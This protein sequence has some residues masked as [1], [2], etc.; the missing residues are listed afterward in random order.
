MEHEKHK[1][2]SPEDRAAALA[3][4]AESDQSIVKVAAELGIDHK[5]LWRWVNKAKL[6]QI[7]PA[8]ELPVEARRRIRDLERQNA[9]LQRDLDFQKKAQAFF[10]EIDQNDNGSN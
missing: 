7:D 3:R 4:V 1:H 6:A 10:R 5:T 9:K 2:Y 8:G